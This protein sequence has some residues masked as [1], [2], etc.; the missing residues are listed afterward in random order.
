MD[1]EVNNRQQLLAVD[2]SQICAQIRQLLAE[3]GVRRGEVSVAIIDDAEIHEL[4]R[5]H[6]QHDYPTDVL[7]FVLER[8][9]D[10]LI[11][12]VIVSAEMALSRC[13]EYD[14]SAECELA[15]YWIHGVLHL[16]GYRDKLEADV[17]VMRQR[18]QHYLQRFGWD[19][20]RNAASLDR[21]LDR[22]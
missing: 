11:G 13:C 8:D 2:E 5:I 1:I 19:A 6:L 14:W 12:E 7:S 15:L 17:I 4:N 10:F 9:G 18:E 22:A 16:V 3:E 21:N 20:S